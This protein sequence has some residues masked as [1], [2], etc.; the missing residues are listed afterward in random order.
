MTVAQFQDAAK[1]HE[2]LKGRLNLRYDVK[3]E[4]IAVEAPNEQA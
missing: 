4:Y 2:V 1:K 3:K